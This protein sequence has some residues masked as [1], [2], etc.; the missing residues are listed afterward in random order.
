MAPRNFEHYVE[1]TSLEEYVERFEV[2]LMI[3]HV[4]DKIEKTVHFISGCGAYLYTKIKSACNPK[5]PMTVPFVELKAL[6][7]GVL[8]PRNIV[9]VEKAKFHVRNQL[10]L[11]GETASEFI[12]ALRKLAQTCNFG[13]QLDS[14]LKDRFVVGLRD[15]TIRSQV[16]DTVSL[17]EAMARATTLEI[18]RGLPSTSSSQLY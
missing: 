17:E 7:N 1:G 12:M 8:Y 3:N 9:A 16:I 4:E 18:S 2:F 13:A 10:E 6:L 15:N 5:T 11:E 14:Q